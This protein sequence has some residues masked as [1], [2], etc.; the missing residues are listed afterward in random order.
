[1]PPPTLKWE[2]H[3]PP[4]PQSLHWNKELSQTNRT[5]PSDLSVHPI[6]VPK[7]EHQPLLGVLR[8]DEGLP[9][10]G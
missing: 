1:M 8:D 7:G 5:Q 3:P 9:K 10:P 2:I 4:T 6:N